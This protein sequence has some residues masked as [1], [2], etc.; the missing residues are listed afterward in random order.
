MNCLNRCEVQA[1][2]DNEAI[3]AEKEEFFQHR[4]HCVD[5]QKLYDEAKAEIETIKGLLSFALADENQIVIPEFR[6]TK[7]P[8]SRKKLLFY[9]S[10][11]A[12][13]L[14]LLGVYILN[15]SNSEEKS[16]TDILIDQYMYQSDPNK[17]WIGKQ[18]I[19]TVTDQNGDLVYIN[20]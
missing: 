12:S 9:C 15:K 13:I 18:P 6:H 10:I 20:N 2:I 1:I 16:K 8:Y 19:I 3:N 14:V 4:Q 7:K 5:C 17:N 11:A